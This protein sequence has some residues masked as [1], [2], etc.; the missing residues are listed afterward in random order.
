MKKTTIC[1]RPLDTCQSFCEP[2]SQNTK[3]KKSKHVKRVLMYWEIIMGKILEIL[4]KAIDESL[5]RSLP[6]ENYIIFKG[7]VFLFPKRYSLPCSL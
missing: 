5:Y 6:M 7:Q 4:T 2:I 1:A 3:T